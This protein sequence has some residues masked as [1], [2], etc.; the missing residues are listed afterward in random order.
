M[1]IL[2]T[3]SPLHYTH[4][5]TFTQP[6]WQTLVLPLLAAIAG[7]TKHTIRL[8]DNTEGWLRSHRI[9]S[10]IRAFKPDLLGVSI[11]AARDIQKTVGVIRQVRQEFASLPIVAGG[12]GAS[13]YDELLVRNGTNVVVRG[14]GEITLRELIAAYGSGHPDFSAIPGITWLEGSAVV[15]RSAA[16]ERIK[17]L[18]DSPF[19]A[20]DLM[21]KRKS[22][23][24]PGRFAGSVETSRGCPFS[25]NF[26]AITSFW[27]GSFR[28]KT[29]VR[30][31]EELKILAAQGRTH[32]YLADDNFGMGTEKHMDLFERIL[33]ANLDVRFFAQM[34]TDTIAENPDMVELGARAGLYGAL[35]GFDTYDAETFHHISKKG[36]IDLN[37][38]CSETLR[39]NGVII[40][41]SH[42]YGLP[43]QKR[44]RD[45]NRTFWVGRRNSDLFRMPHFSLLPGTRAYNTM[46]TEEVIQDAERRNDDFRFLVRA[47]AERRAFKALYHVYTLLHV[48]L[49]DEILKALFHPNRN[50]RILKRMGYWGTCRHYAYRALRKVKGTDI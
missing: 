18:D 38:R 16:R 5:H 15:K 47:P 24:F 49:P 34:R 32:V 29:N 21:P 26:C 14:E 23:W 27:E 17:T 37:H 11:I 41:G 45:F 46:V 4:G 2:F 13:F 22:R 8:V 40:L 25:C 28:T 10:E 42:I 1:K 20:F 43:S 31:V 6:D 30:I 9:L 50:A 3:N 7:E 12:Q 39:R 35:I 19:P 48:L 33:S 44:P 36:S